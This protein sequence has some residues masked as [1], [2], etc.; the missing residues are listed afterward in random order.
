MSQ[1]AD[2]SGR[3]VIANT[4]A[5]EGEKIAGFVHGVCT[6]SGLA[7]IESETGAF[8]VVNVNHVDSASVSVSVSASA[9]KRLP[10]RLPERMPGPSASARKL[11]SEYARTAP[12]SVL[13][14]C[15]DAQLIF[16][17]LD[18]TLNAIWCSDGALEVLEG[19]V[20]ITPPYIPDHADSKDPDALRRVRLVL[21]RERE[22]LRDKLGGM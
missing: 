7:V 16:D 14:A 3:W 9:S 11:A 6:R 8:V 18:K 10:D 21:Q 1:L 22:R 15:P 19:L 12:A 5:A 2:A 13:A 17:A 20:R 4:S